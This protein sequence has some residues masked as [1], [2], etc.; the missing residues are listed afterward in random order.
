MRFLPDDIATR[1]LQKV[2]EGDD[3]AAPT[4]SDQAVPIE[5][6]AEKVNTIVRVL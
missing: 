5:H 4:Q 2:I 3:A 6:P 1:Y